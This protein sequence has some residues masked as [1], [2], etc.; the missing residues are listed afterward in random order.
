MVDM[1]DVIF[2]YVWQFV[3]YYVWQ[4]FDIQIVGGDIGCY[5]YVN[6]VGFK[7]GQCVGMCFLVFVVMDCCVVDVVFVELFCEVVGVMF[8]MGKYQYLLLVVFVDKL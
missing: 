1:V 4:F 8:G 3:V 7:V 5:Q 6:V 2:W